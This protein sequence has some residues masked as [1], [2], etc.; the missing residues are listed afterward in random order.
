MPV[1]QRT[2]AAEILASGDPVATGTYEATLDRS[3]PAVGTARRTTAKGVIR[4]RSR[5]TALRAMV[6]RLVRVR[7]D[8]RVELPIEVTLYVPAAGFIAFTCSDASEL[9]VDAAAI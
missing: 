6:G 4:L 7:F 2:G 8:W 9:D 5:E 1:I 3:V